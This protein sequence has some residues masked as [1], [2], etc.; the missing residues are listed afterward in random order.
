MKAHERKKRVYRDTDDRY[1]RDLAKVATVPT[2][3]YMWDVSETLVRLWCESGVVC[4]IKDGGVWLISLRS[5]VSHRG[6][7]VL[8]RTRGQ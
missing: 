2:V 4:A 6:A 7:V 3:A 1:L 8:H 5:V